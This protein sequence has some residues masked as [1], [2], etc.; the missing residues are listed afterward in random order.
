LA[1]I[2][3]ALTTN[4]YLINMVNEADRYKDIIIRGIKEIDVSLDFFDLKKHNY[5]RGN[6]NANITKNEY[7]S[8]RILPGGE[9]TPSTYLISNEYYIGHIKE[10]KILKKI[11]DTRKLFDVENRV[12][13]KYC[14][15]TACQLIRECGG[16]EYDRRYLWY[17]TLEE[18]DYY[19]PSRFDKAIY[20][21]KI[22]F[23]RPQGFS[24]IHE[25]YL[26]TM[27]FSN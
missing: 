2:I 21:R 10:N 19:C 13:P 16:G 25:E 22:K 7:N 6:K 17:K 23:D 1:A 3:Q 4:G 14:Q 12:I 11:I 15:T 20:N 26:P 8:L 18:R 9:I 24:A 27:F 5:F